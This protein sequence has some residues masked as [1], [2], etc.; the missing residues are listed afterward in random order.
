MLMLKDFT[1]KMLMFQSLTTGAKRNNRKWLLFTMMSKVGISEQPCRAQALAKAKSYPHYD[2]MKGYMVSPRVLFW[3]HILKLF[4][5]E[6][7]SEVWCT[8]IQLK[9]SLM[10]EISFSHQRQSSKTRFDNEAD[11]IRK[12]PIIFSCLWR[13]SFCHLGFR[14]RLKFWDFLRKS[15]TT[16]ADEKFIQHYNR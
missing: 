3:I 10:N 1:L 8:T 14:H 9:M 12:W 5:V 11:V 2:A 7:A 15:E 6:S 4:C 16:K 13:R